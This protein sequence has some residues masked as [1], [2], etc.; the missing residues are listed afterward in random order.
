MVLTTINS[1]RHFGSAFSYDI[2]KQWRLIDHIDVVVRTDDSK[3]S[4]SDSMVMRSNNFKN[5]YRMFDVPP[6]PHMV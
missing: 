5:D 2:N 4:M 6:P 3:K 1:E